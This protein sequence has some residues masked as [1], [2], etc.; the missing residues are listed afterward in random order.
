MNLRIRKCTIVDI[1]KGSRV[2]FDFFFEFPN[3]DLTR[4]LVQ[5]LRLFVGGRHI[6]SGFSADKKS[7]TMAQFIVAGRSSEL[8]RKEAVD[9]ILL[10]GADKGE[11]SKY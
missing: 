4:G 7:R 5:C 10:N 1:V 11:I 3:L 9:R 6:A 2:G 8:K